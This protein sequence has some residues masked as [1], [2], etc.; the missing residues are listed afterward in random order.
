MNGHKACLFNNE[1]EHRISPCVSS[2]SSCTLQDPQEAQQSRSSTIIK[3]KKAK[4][5]LT[6]NPLS[7]SLAIRPIFPLFCS[8]T[9]SHCIPSPLRTTY[10]QA[11]T[12][13]SLVTS[14]PFEED[15][16]L[17]AWSAVCAST[18]PKNYKRHAQL[19]F[20]RLWDLP[21]ALKVSINCCPW[22]SFLTHTISG[23]FR[24][25]S[26]PTTLHWFLQR[27]LAVL[28]ISACISFP[29]GNDLWPVCV[30]D[31]LFLFC[32]LFPR[33]DV[34]DLGTSM[35]PLRPWDEWKRAPC[36]LWLKFQTLPRAGL[37]H[38]LEQNREFASILLTKK[39]TI[40]RWKSELNPDILRPIPQPRKK[41][42][43]PWQGK[44]KCMD[45]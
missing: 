29:G 5:L 27:F 10:T 26:K 32:W 41:E 37:E 34:A 15:F 21:T 11:A 13:L 14:K 40:G 8:W 17:L 7:A 23:T 39:E 16:Q 30:S 33:V 28:Q 25:P 3:F 36:L 19:P 43:F 24:L 6:W 4:H 1:H 35:W 31:T 38:H 42:C 45:C 2:D 18:S 22:H 44:P 20:Q 12:Y 9:L